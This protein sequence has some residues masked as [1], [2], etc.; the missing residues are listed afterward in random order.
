MNEYLNANFPIFEACQKL[1]E[2]IDVEYGK[3][4]YKMFY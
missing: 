1:N 2:R 4:I 3:G